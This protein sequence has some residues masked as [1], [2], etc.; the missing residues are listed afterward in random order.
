MIRRLL[1]GKI[2]ILPPS[3]SLIPVLSESRSRSR[4]RS[5]SQDIYFALW[6]VHAGKLGEKGPHGWDRLFVFF[7]YISGAQINVIWLC[8]LC[9]LWIIF[10]QSLSRSRTL[11]QSICF[12]NIKWWRM[13]NNSSCRQVGRACGD[14]SCFGSFW[15][16]ISVSSNKSV[17]MLG[18]RGTWRGQQRGWWQ[19][20][21]TMEQV[22]VNFR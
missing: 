5:R 14:G 6:W 15:S 22:C 17:G 18:E 1:F 21:Y 11:S 16:S 2:P 20:G 4:S 3:G 8:V 9:V 10:Q 7:R 19:E 12:S 13:N